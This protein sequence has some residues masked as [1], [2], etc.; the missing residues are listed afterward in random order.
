MIGLFFENGPLRVTED[1]KLARQAIHWADEYSVL[2]IDQPVGTGYSYVTRRSD[3]DDQVVTDKATLHKIHEAL[4]SELRHDQE[5]E[6]RFFASHINRDLPFKSEADRLHKEQLLEGEDPLFHN[7]YVKDQRAVVQDL[8]VFLDQ[9]YERYPEQQTRELYLAGE[10]YAGKYIP[11]LAYGIL[12]SNKGRRHQHSS[13]DEDNKVVAVPEQFVIPLKGI[14]L[15]NSLTDPASQVQIHADH[16]FYLGLVTKKQADRMR[17]LQTMSVQEAEKGRFVASN[18]HRLAVFE[19]F[20]NATGGLNWYDIRKGSV[21]N[22]WSRMETF[23]NT[24]S[25]K[26]SL[27]VFGPR[28]A[29]LEA[30]G[31]PAN[32]IERIEKGREQTKYNKDPVVIKTMAGDIMKS[33]AWMVSELLQNNIKV[34]AF[35]GVFDFRD[36]VAGSQTWLDELDWAKQEEFLE[37]E[38]ELWIRQGQLAGF[39]TRVPGLAKVVVLGAGHLAPMDQPTASLELIR[40]LVQGFEEMKLKKQGEHIQLQQ[41]II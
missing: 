10:S 21:A 5:K 16:A 1:M 31:V 30:Q 23:L 8:L 37:S 13:Q 15:G 35:Q 7:G 40:G 14:A 25:V 20:K 29:F 34:L 38:R 4:R 3:E 9:F 11:A 17:T 41:H 22:D 6:E 33:T 12:E 2:F 27:N 19:T 36:G 24:P 32:E 18:E 39:I 26:D 28:K